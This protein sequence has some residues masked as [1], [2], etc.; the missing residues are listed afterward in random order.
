MLRPPILRET[1]FFS[2]TLHPVK[3]RQFLEKCKINFIKESEWIPCSPD[4]AP[5]DYGIW[6]WMKSKLRFKKAGT[7][8]GLKNAVQKVWN[9][10]PQT[11]I[12]KVL[13]AWPTQVYQ[14]CK[15]KGQHI[16]HLR[17]K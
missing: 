8:K 2:R 5:M 13:A 16:E 12:D 1:S 15:A 7:V 9:E 4:A 11:M 6:A 3:T 10:L 17:K 14:I